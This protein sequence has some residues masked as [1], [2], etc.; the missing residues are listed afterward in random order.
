[1][2]RCLQREKNWR[3]RQFDLL[4]YHAVKNLTCGEGGGITCSEDWIARKLKELRWVGIS[5]DTWIRSSAESVYA[6]Q[7]FVDKVGYKYHMSDMQ[8]AIGVVQLG[9]LEQLNARRREV[10]D[11]YSEQL[12]EVEWLEL[13]HEKE[14]ARSSWHLY[15]IKLPDEA[16]RDRLI[17]HMKDHNIAPGVH[18]YPCHLQPSYIH[19]KAEVPVSG[20]VWKR[21]LTL[22]IHPNLTDEDLARIVACVKSLEI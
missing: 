16:S 19:L 6:W 4:S 10:A 9:K 5:K 13:P 18:Y 22:P 21:I 12:R 2:R 20:E 3:H 17:G 7:Y 11:Y 8:A 1:M 14:Y 15:Q